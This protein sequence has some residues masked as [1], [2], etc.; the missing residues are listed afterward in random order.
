MSETPSEID[1]PEPMPGCFS[2]MRH[3]RGH[4]DVWVH[5]EVGSVEYAAALAELRAKHN[6]PPRSPQTGA[7]P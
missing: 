7:R 4:P 5:A 3:P 6:A 1:E 2:P